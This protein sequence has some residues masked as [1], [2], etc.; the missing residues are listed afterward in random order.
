MILFLAGT[1]LAI[2]VVIGAAY[3]FLRVLGG[4]K[5][6]FLGITIETLL[7][8]IFWPITVFLFWKGKI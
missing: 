6:S 5:G 8:A 2:A 1:Y 7:S 4:K 3:C